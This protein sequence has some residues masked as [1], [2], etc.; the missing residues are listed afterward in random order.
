MALET[1]HFKM[2]KNEKKADIAA[3]EAT[4]ASA[5]RLFLASPFMRRCWQSHE[6]IDGV[7]IE[8][9]KGKTEARFGLGED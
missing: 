1:K 9:S 2:I 6:F 8:K 7:R 4:T 3:K 5:I